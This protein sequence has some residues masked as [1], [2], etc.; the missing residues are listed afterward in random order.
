MYDPSTAMHSLRAQRVLI[1]FSNKLLDLAEYVL[2]IV[3]EEL[4]PNAE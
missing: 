4:P 1:Q 2:R 3:A